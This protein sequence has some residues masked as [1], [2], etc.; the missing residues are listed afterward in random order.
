MI[1]S[2]FL[3]DHAKLEHLVTRPE[4]LMTH[5]VF[6]V[7]NWRE[8]LGESLT[9]NQWH[10]APVIF[11]W[12]SSIL[13]APCPFIIG[14]RVYETHFAYMGIPNPGHELLTVKSWIDRYPSL[15]D[16]D[17][18]TANFH[19]V[20]QITCEPRWYLLPPFTD[21]HG[22]AHP[23]P[24]RRKSGSHI[25]AAYK[26]TCLVAE[27]TGLVLYRLIHGKWPFHHTKWIGCKA[28]EGDFSLELYISVVNDKICIKSA[29]GLSARTLNT[30]SVALER[31]S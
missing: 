3:E 26:E 21:E 14:K 12:S 9:S 7:D 20:W 1:T 13:L 27:V 10:Q 28:R 4:A 18:P 24:G 31:F 29:S 8:L 6:N 5:K 16:I 25:F 11:P 23:V 2:T 30:R 19:A 17:A 22:N 15:F